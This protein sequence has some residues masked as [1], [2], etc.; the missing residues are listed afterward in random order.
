L[1]L[2]A[3]MSSIRT[4]TF[5]LFEMFSDAESARVYLEGRLWPNGTRCP[6]CGMGMKRLA[7]PL[8]SYS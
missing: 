4:R 1:S 5:Q 8:R 3:A 6:V 2:R 7:V